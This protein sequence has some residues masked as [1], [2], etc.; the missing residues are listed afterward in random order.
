M[1]DYSRKD[2]WSGRYDTDAAPGAEPYEWYLGFDELRDILELLPEDK[3]QQIVYVGCGISTL[4][5]EL[6]KEGFSNVT[7]VDWIQK[8]VDAASKFLPEELETPPSFAC[9]DIADST[10][11]NLAAVL[12]KG[13]LD[14]FL[15]GEEAKTATT[16][17]IDRIHGWLAVGSPLILISHSDRTKL[18]GSSTLPWDCSVRQV[19]SGEGRQF[20]L[21]VCRR[22]DPPPEDEAEERE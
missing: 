10:Y 12:D 8:A 9:A 22:V 21:H 3:A 18:F 7:C 19:E 16:A 1:P 15:T 20:F 17:L 14:S 6:A 4:G 2:Y 5:I 13:L 11:E